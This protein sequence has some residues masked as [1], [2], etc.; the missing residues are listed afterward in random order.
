MNRNDSLRRCVDAPISSQSSAPQA[1]ATDQKRDPECD[2]KAFVLP[3]S[4]G[5]ED[6]PR[7]DEAHADAGPETGRSSFHGHE[8]TRNTKPTC[9]T[10]EELLLSAAG[11]S[12]MARIHGRPPRWDH[13]RHRARPHPSR[14][15]AR[16]RR[17]LP[18]PGIRTASYE[19][20]RW[21]A[22]GLSRAE[23]IARQGRTRRCPGGVQRTE[24]E[25]RA[26]PGERFSILGTHRPGP[27][28]RRMT[29]LTIPSNP[30]ESIP[31]AGMT[32][33]P[34][35]PAGNGGGGTAGPSTG[36]PGPLRR[37]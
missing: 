30:F 8:P 1:E 7:G 34:N 13:P 32:S 11:S 5:Q 16:R 33:D 25:C 6:N 14:S 12:C 24:F 10:V 19:A 29:D 27:L 22:D 15:G 36:R 37:H 2:A 31:G 9:R 18:A 26:D 17:H 23:W 21:A 35:A 20:T 28:E 3:E 4:S